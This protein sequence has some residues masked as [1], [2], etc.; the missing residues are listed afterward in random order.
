DPK[1]KFQ[2]LAF[3][4]GGRSVLW[5]GWS[6]RFI[7]SELDDPNWPDEVKRDLMQNVL[8]PAAPR[9]SYLDQASRQIGTET[10]NDFIFG[11]LHSALRKRVFDGLMAR[12]PDLRPV[13][14]G[15]RGKLAEPEDLEA[16]LAVQS[17]SVRAGSLPVNKFNGVQLVIR[18]ARLAQS[19]AQTS[20]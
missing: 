12:A 20:S 3:C 11:P 6:P 16:P 7:E 2:G 5:G 9:E 15:N 10:P 1:L 17:A 18:A 8:P 14:T 4:L 13:L 19:E